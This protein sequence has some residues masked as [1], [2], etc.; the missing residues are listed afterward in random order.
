NNFQPIQWFR[1]VEFDRDWNVRSQPFTGDQYLS[2]AGIKFIGKNASAIGYD[3]ENFVWGT[4][5]IGYR[6]NLDVK[7]KKGGFNYLA[8]GSWLLSDGLE[9][10]SFLRHNMSISQN[11]RFIKIGV[12]DI[13]ESNEKR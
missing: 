12:D 4:D 13:H 5:Y 7:L 9:Q 2:N 1:S 6:N 8:N 3:F 10:T 11:M